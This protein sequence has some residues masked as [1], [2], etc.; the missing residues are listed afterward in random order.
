MRI[1]FVSSISKYCLTFLLL[2]G[3]NQTLNAQQFSDNFDA[4]LVPGAGNGYA[5]NE[6]LDI[7]QAGDS[8]PATYAIIAGTPDMIQVNSDIPDAAGDESG[9]G[10]FSFISG[11]AAVQL[12]IVP[13]DSEVSFR[14]E[15]WPVANNAA[16]DSADWACL[17]MGATGGN[18]FVNGAAAGVGM[19]I[20]DNGGYQVFNNGPL[21]ADGAVDV[22]DSYIIEASLN[23]AGDSYSLTI[24]GTAVLT[25]AAVTT[26]GTLFQMGGLGPAPH[27]IDDLEI[28]F[29]VKNIIPCLTATPQGGE[30]PLDVTFNASCT[31]AV[32]DIASYSW[33]FGDGSQDTGE[34]VS[35]T[36]QFGDNYTVTLTVEDVDGNTETAT[37]VITVFD[38]L[39]SYEDDFERP[40][41]PVEGWTPVSGNWDIVGGQLE[42][43]T[44]GGENWVWAGSPPVILPE[45]M[46]LSFTYDFLV[47][48]GDGVGRHGGLMFC[49]SEPNTR[50]TGNGYTIDWIDRAGDHGIRVIR[51]DNGAHTVLQNGTPAVAEPPLEWRIVV[52]AATILIYGDGQLLVTVND[53]T[54]RGGFLGFWAWINNEHIALDNVSVQEPDVFC[55]P[56]ITTRSDL[57]GVGLDRVFDSSESEA[58]EDITSV[59]WDFGDGNNSSDAV[60]THSYDAPGTYDVTLTVN[61]AG[62]DS[63]EVTTQVRVVETVA[64]FFDDFARADGNPDGWTPV[65]GNWSI[66]GE[67]LTVDAPQGPEPFIYAG[68]PPRAF[69]DVVELEFDVSFINTP[70]DGIGRHGGLFLFGQDPL[71]RGQTSGYTIDWIDREADRGYRIIVLRNGVGEVLVNG[72]G[73]VEPGEIWRVELDGDTIRLVVDGEVK[74]EVVEGSYRTGYMGMWSFV[75]GQLI[76]FDNVTFGE[77]PVA[78]ACFS[79][80]PAGDLNA[81]EDATFNAD[82]SKAPGSSITSYSWDFG[83]GNV[84]DG[85][86]VEHTFENG[87]IY[88][89]TLTIETADG[90]IATN[91]ASVTVVETLTGFSDDFEQENGPPEN[92]TIVNDHEWQVVDGS[93][94]TEVPAAPEAWIWAGSP[95]HKFVDIEEMSFDLTFNDIPLDVVGRHA[96]VAFFM[97]NTLPRFQGNSGYTIDWIDRPDDKG[98]RVL[99]WVDGVSTLLTI[100]GSDDNG[101]GVEWVIE[102]EEEIFR[103][104]VDG[105]V[106]TD[107]DGNDEVFDSMFREGHF[108]FWSYFNGQNLD[109]DNVVIG[110]GGIII[111]PGDEFRRGDTDGNGAL[112]IT[113]PINNLSFQFLG[114]FTP[115]CLDAADFDDNGKVEITDPIANLSHQ[116]LGTAPPA[117]PGKDTCGVDP[118]E[119]DESVGGDLGCLNPPENC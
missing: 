111:Q 40:D 77:P 107:I 66:A 6:D 72:T 73:D 85:P 48:P 54:H 113:D 35:H 16:R 26:S 100:L 21:I 80:D 117:P 86:V 67:T 46:E 102:V 108:G 25:D 17:N 34:E 87:D 36:Y 5:L 60:A 71:P 106:K 38:T 65:S 9:L 81:G 53:P 95:P 105:D 74:A 30:A 101:P 4:E 63:C 112:E 14:A 29:E 75:N 83:D 3:I 58:S 69:G 7:R 52:T 99:Q 49:A 55:S 98:Y 56:N 44:A 23:A 10:R 97:Q 118:T 59:N 93:L 51:V 1:G 50:A 41:G 91:T 28:D 61:V 47:T 70:A 92:W 88:D 116:F 104:I 43:Q 82:C 18:G 64:G 114:T 89:V 109:Y 90:D 13:I 42:T 84:A 22:A 11:F 45:V 119:D 37:T 12:D 103:L 31:T 33:D 79:I 57:L 96:G 68:S 8:T 78:D 20:R 39:D 27:I 15:V 115:P 32:A 94:H 24:N 62:G 110:D 2:L 19:L 76:E